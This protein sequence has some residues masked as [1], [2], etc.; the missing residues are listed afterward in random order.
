MIKFKEEIAKSISKVTNIDVEELM[1]YI[2][3]PANSEMGDYA[4]PCFKLAKSLRKSPQIIA[5]EINENISIDENI[6]QKIEIVNGY[7]N[8][9]INSKTLVGTVLEELENKKENYG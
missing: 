7:V 3:V 1:Q 8:F 2:E 6:I 5:N 9:Y 4:F